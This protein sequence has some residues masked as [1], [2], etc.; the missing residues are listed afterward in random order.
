MI[1][2]RLLRQARTPNI[3]ADSMILFRVN[4]GPFLHDP[5]TG[6]TRKKNDQ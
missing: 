2:A 1:D 4:R 3:L 5:L 6:E